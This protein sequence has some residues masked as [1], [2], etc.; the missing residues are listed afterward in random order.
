MTKFLRVVL[1][2]TLLT[3]TTSSQTQTPLSE[4][5]SQGP[6]FSGLETG[7]LKDRQLSESI[8]SSLARLRKDNPERADE[9]ETQLT[10]KSTAISRVTQAYKYL[11]VS[12]IKLN[13]VEQL[14]RKGLISLKD[15][16]NAVREYQV[17]L[18]LIELNRQTYFGEL[19][20]T[21]LKFNEVRN[22]LNTF[23]E[24]TTEWSK[25]YSSLASQNRRAM[26]LPD[27]TL[28]RIDLVL[29]KVYVRMSLA[30]LKNHYFIKQMPQQPKRSCAWRDT[31]KVLDH[32]GDDDGPPSFGS[33]I[34]IPER[35][36]SAYAGKTATCWDGVINKHPQSPTLA[37]CTYKHIS[38]A[39]YGDGRSPGRVYECFCR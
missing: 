17:S 22:L 6:D 18:K 24:R 39:F 2:I 35:C 31:K 9:M 4:A 15:Y 13:W 20:E 7:P 38:I 34:P 36:H 25:Q 28:N 8:K 21:N 1:A 33:N 27:L 5:I 16:S 11:V 26:G 19:Y 10:R 37:W 14:S 30:L 32:T 23:Q 3:F 29:E 12:E